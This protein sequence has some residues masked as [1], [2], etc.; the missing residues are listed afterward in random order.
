MSLYISYILII[1]QIPM[2]SLF[3][4]L[5]IEKVKWNKL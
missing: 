4:K 3:M 5:D 2:T 1:S